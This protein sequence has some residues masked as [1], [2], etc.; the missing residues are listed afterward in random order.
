MYDRFLLFLLS[1]YNHV[2]PKYCQR[3]KNDD[4]EL[5]HFNFENYYKENGFVKEHSYY[6]MECLKTKNLLL[7]GTKLI[8][9][10]SR[11]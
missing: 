2:Y 10:E 11:H 6:S 1:Q 8:K 3:Y 5:K 9:I 4:N 7:L